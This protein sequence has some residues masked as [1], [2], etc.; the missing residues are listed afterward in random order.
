MKKREF[1]KRKLSPKKI[2][3][4]NISE[5]NH[6]KI[7]KLLFKRKNTE[8][9]DISHKNRQDDIDH[10]INIH[11]NKNNISHDIDN[12]NNRN[13]KPLN[14]KKNNVN[15]LPNKIN[16]KKNLEID[17]SVN[18]APLFRRRRVNA[19]RD[20]GKF[21]KKNEQDKNENLNID[22]QIKINR[23]ID[24]INNNEHNN[25]RKEELK[26][27]NF[28][29]R[30][31]N[32]ENCMTCNNNENINLKL[33]NEDDNEIK[34]IKNNKI[35]MIPKPQ[36][37]KVI[38]KKQID[39]LDINLNINELIENNNNNN[40]KT[41]NVDFKPKYVNKINQRI[42]RSNIERNLNS[43]SKHPQN[44]DFLFDD[45]NFF[46]SVLLILNFINYIHSYLPKNKYKILISEE[47]NEYCLSSILYYIYEY[48]WVL[49][50][51]K[52][53]SEIEI[54]NL[55][56]SFMECYIRTNFN[57]QNIDNCLYNINNLQ[58]ITN[59]I[60]DKINQELTAENK[61]KKMLEIN[62]RDKILY[63][64]MVEF[65][66]N[67]KSVVSDDFTGFYQKISTCF[68]C[69]FLLENKGFI[70]E[71]NIKYTPF[72]YLYFDYRPY[73]NNASF[74]NNSYIPN[75]NANSGVKYNIHDCFYKKYKTL[76][77]ESC[78]FC[79][80]INNR[81][82]R[83]LYS[84]PNVLTIIIN[85][86]EGNFFVN[87]KIN[88]SQYMKKMIGNNNYYLIAMLCKNY[89]NN[90]LVIYCYNPK[91]NEWYLYA[92]TGG[93]HYKKFRTTTYLEPNAIPYLLVYE[94]VEK[95]DFEYHDI[96]LDI[97][98]NKK[99]YKFTF[100]NGHPTT[101]IFFGNNTTIK[102][103]RKQIEK[104]YDLK[105]VKLVINAVKV[106]DNDLLINVNKNNSPIMVIGE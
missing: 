26:K 58:F 47:K 103:V 29:N 51:T 19:E 68:S 36:K 56:E 49:D 75:N 38:Q 52:T 98:N 30:K 89:F 33:D 59:F 106:N 43:E 67:N 93:K 14:L 57:N 102:E 82:Q 105:N 18:N 81:V 101:E 76:S 10:D 9:N 15:A 83:N 104:N 60:F 79:K 4:E 96:N 40:N 16:I 50:K 72:K 6:Q 63:N 62:S 71:P 12:S 24:N 7:N 74:I 8:K 53:K 73:Q 54:K 80:N 20:L 22:N 21:I 41:K 31:I 88:L 69:Q 28:R 90:K 35:N 95:M 70:Y 66:K 13:N 44:I 91:N 94:N 45:F 23:D 42:K 3:S 34:I 11:F 100:Q 84:L 99:K 78:Q 2:Q 85:N 77:Q 87:D 32:R 64:Y 1:I 25:K 92:K 86:E 5:D 65:Y 27:I 46:D 55:Y 37:F 97:S 17:T 48:L 61:D 39:D